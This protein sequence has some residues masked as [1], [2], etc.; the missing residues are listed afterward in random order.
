MQAGEGWQSQGPDAQLMEVDSAPFIRQQ[1]WLPLLGCIRKDLIICLRVVLCT[2]GY[3][4]CLIEKPHLPG[5]QDSAADL[6]CI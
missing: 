1:T 6:Q 4:T 2:H 3:S 5:R